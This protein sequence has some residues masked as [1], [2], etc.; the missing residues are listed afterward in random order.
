MLASTSGG[1]PSVAAGTVFPA[2]APASVT[3]TVSGGPPGPTENVGK[4]DVAGWPA[5]RGGILF[6]RHG[7]HLEL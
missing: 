2:H 5:E 1:L 7:L 4:H 6:D 3:A